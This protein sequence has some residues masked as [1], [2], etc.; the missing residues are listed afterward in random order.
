VPSEDYRENQPAHAGRIKQK[1][2]SPFAWH[3]LPYPRSPTAF[4]LETHTE[5]NL[6]KVVIEN[7]IFVE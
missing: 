4:A 5:M 1:Q 7:Y 2:T 6:D 3:L